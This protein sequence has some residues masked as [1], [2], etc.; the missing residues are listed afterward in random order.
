M[1]RSRLL[2][3]GRSMRFRLTVLYGGLFL[4]AGIGLLAITYVLVDHSTT[5]ALFVDNKNGERV[6]VRG[7]QLGSSTRS[8]QLKTGTPSPEQLQVARQLAAQA[9]AQHTHDLHQLVTQSAIALGVMAVLAVVLG[10]L[11]AGRVLRPLRTMAAA[12]QQIT[13]RNLHERL[14]LSGPNDEVKHLADTIDGLLARLDNAFQAQ[15]RFVANASHELRT[16]L[17][18]DRALLEVALADPDAS[19][20]ELRATLEELLASGEQQERLIEALL[21]LAS[22]ERG[23]DRREPVDLAAA[24]EQALSSIGPEAARQG[25][26]VTSSI[27]AAPLTGNRALVERMIANLMENAVR[28][29]V[30]GGSIDLRTECQRR[31][32]CAHRGQLRPLGVTRRRRPAL[33]AIP[34]PR[35]RP[36]HAPWRARTRA[37]HRPG[38]RHRPRRRPEDT[39]P[40]ERWAHRADLLSAFTR[41]REQSQRRCRAGHGRHSASS[42]SRLADRKMRTKSEPVLTQCAGTL[43]DCAAAADIFD[44]LFM[45]RNTARP[46]VRGITGDR[47]D[48]PPDVAWRGCR[49]VLFGHRSARVL[50]DW[51]LCSRDSIESQWCASNA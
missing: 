14:A 13:E 9:T 20:E 1:V 15:R 3:S 18:F 51:N 31:I 30:P 34:A 41:R 21:T 5:T 45:D 19:S 39:T 47:C 23:L 32:S 36:H 46:T 48:S 43:S 50:R 2:L 33:P 7:G 22:S 38:G 11:V 27:E 42:K 8:P 24:A 6:A 37:L 25:L 17:T 29:N 26:Q 10:W 49:V 12:T 40:S 4:V 44:P 35:Q 28:Y 16:P